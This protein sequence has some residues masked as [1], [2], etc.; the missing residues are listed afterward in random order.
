MHDWFDL[1]G[2][3]GPVL[4]AGLAGGVLRAL[5]RHRYKVREMVASPICGALAAAYL[6]LP[7]VSYF[8]ATGLPVPSP[9]D[10]TTTLA[11]AFLIGVSAMWISDILF[12]FVVRKF[13]PATEE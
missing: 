1:L 10:D 12:E 11:A 2:I 9:D 4:A 5:S 13:K 3:K 7:V 8:K 6:T